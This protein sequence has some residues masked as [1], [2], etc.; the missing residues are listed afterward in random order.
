MHHTTFSSQMMAQMMNGQQTSGPCPPSQTHAMHFN[1]TMNTNTLYQT[2]YTQ[3]NPNVY[4]HGRR[5]TMQTGLRSLDL[6]RQLGVDIS[7]LRYMDYAQL[8][9]NLFSANWSKR[10]NAFADVPVLNV[11]QQY[12]KPLNSNITKK[13]NWFNK[14]RPYSGTFTKNE[15]YNNSGISP[16]P[17]TPKKYYNNLTKVSDV[18][19]LSGRPE[20]NKHL[21]IRSR[22]ISLES[23]LGYIQEYCYTQNICPPISFQT[24]RTCMRKHEKGG[25]PALGRI[26][27]KGFIDPDRYLTESRLMEI[28]S[29]PG[30][31]VIESIKRDDLSRQIW[32]MFISNQQTESTYRNKI[33]LWKN[34][35]RHIRKSYRRYDL[36]MIGSTMN[37]FGLESSDVDMCL[38]VRHEKVDNRDTALLHL[39]QTLRCLQRYKSVENL[40]I[41]QAKVPIINF[42][43]SRQNLNVDINCNSSVAIVNTHLLYCYSRIDWRVKPL[44]LIVKLWAQFHKINSARNNTLSSYSLALMVIS[45]LQCGVNPPILPNLQYHTSHFRSFYHEDIQPII[46]DIHKKD[47]G[48]IYVDSSFYPSKNTQSLGELLHEFFKYYL[49]FEFE[50]HAV[51][52]EAGYKIKKET[53][54]SAT[55]PNNNRGHWKYIGIEEPFDRTNTAKAVFD[56][57]IFYR[58]QSVIGQ[59]YKRLADSN[60]LNSLF[61]EIPEDQCPS[62][63]LH[64]FDVHAI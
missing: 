34:L 11:P 42:H 43:D 22:E 57:K 26:F 3:Y 7:S 32:S 41:I 12:T 27:H 36:I 25:F 35:Q 24:C 1:N 9:N 56:K 31:F 2:N 20:I 19:G 59:S 18:T 33:M 37:G 55:Y 21:A 8:N 13:P 60:D 48:P 53:C 16:C 5:R 38:L 47:L 51:S 50:H 52:I 46:E 44:V 63:E 61:I 4:G 45:F 29:V 58:I 62:S 10:M 14:E 64:E 54:R 28:T 49:S 6:L 23:F 40:E 17:P 39:N 30:N 15:S